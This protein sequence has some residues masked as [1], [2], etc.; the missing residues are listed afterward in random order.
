MHGV[1][2]MLYGPKIIPM[3]QAQYDQI[4]P[5]PNNLYMVT[6]VNGDVNMYL[7]SMRMAAAYAVGEM[8]NSM[9]SAGRSVVGNFE[10][11]E[12]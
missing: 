7:G 9:Q 3:T 12:D 8:S 11:L 5:D 10:V 4:T 1:K 2:D 6:A